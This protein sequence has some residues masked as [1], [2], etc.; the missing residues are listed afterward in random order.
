MF[1]RKSL[2]LLFYYSHKRGAKNRL[3]NWNETHPVCIFA[4]QDATIYAPFLPLSPEKKLQK[5]KKTSL[6]V[7]EPPN[8]CLSVL[9]IIHLAI[10]SVHC[11]C[12]KSYSSVAKIFSAR[13]QKW[14]SNCSTLL[15][16]VSS[17]IGFVPF[18]EPDFLHL[19]SQ[20]YPPSHTRMWQ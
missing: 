17:Q 4:L 12:M 20:S 19:T 11:W 10:S 2:H 1:V 7:V 13:G 16:E 3:A 5:C 8:I 6:G 14:H 15:G 18:C 9:H